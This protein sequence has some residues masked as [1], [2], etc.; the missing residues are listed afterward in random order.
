MDKKCFLNFFAVMALAIA[1]VGFVSC[2]SDD[3]NG[4]GGADTSLDGGKGLQTPAFESV[5]ALYEV[6]SPDSPVRSIE[7]TA[8]GD[9]II[10]QN[11]YYVYDAPKRAK[12][13][14]KGAAFMAKALATRAGGS[15]IIYGK[16]TKVSDT[17]FVLEGWGT[18]TLTGSS[19][20][21]QSITVTPQGGSE[22]YVVPVAKHTQYA[23]SDLTNKI[24]R[25]WKIST[26]RYVITLDN[27]QILN[28]E[29]AVTKAG[30]QKLVDDLKALSKKYASYFDDDDDDEYDDEED[31]YAEWADDYEIPEYVVFTKAG[32]YMVYY[33]EDRL[34][35]STWAWK[36]QSKGQLR[37]SWNYETMENDYWAGTVNVAFRGDQLA[38]TEL[39][40]DDYDDE[41]DFETSSYITW[42][43]DEKK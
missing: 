17:E 10:V 11:A 16:Y 25:T 9:Y 5:S 21:A 38:I 28:S 32:S 1:S 12:G 7:L 36:D 22:P 26:F 8:S 33:N 43:L 31:D 15:G 41:D 29:Y 24:C 3:D 42:Y 27:K 39:V 30:F 23:D 40:D 4:G 6:T 35:V 2:S 20:D 19:D 18:I 37:Y 34:G 14:L 13:V